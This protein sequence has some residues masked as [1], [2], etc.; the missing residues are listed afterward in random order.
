MI[1]IIIVLCLIPLL[2]SITVAGKSGTVKSGSGINVDISIPADNHPFLL[3]EVTEIVGL[4]E[5]NARLKPD[6]LSPA[7]ENSILKQLVIKLVPLAEYIPPDE[8][9]TQL[10]RKP[11]APLKS[12][13]PAVKIDHGKIVY[14]RIDQF[15]LETRK[16][17]KNE[18]SNI[19]AK[20][21]PVKGI[22]IDLRSCYG[23]DFENMIEA[24]RLLF[25][26]AGKIIRSTTAGNV[27]PLRLPVITLISGKTYGAAEVFAAV[28][29]SSPNSSTVGAATAGEPFKME[30]FSLS[31]GGRLSIPE[32]PVSI[33]E[34]PHFPV[35]PVVAAAPFPI[36]DFK[37]LES[38]ATS[39]QCI[40]VASD[41]LVSIN[42]LKQTS[43]KAQ[44]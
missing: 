7:I 31:N 12:A 8:V 42:T 9:K 32:I 40:C 15:S 1:K 39:D 29:A 5:K 4:L 30:Y 41:L 25:P 13:Y 16:L 6:K 2:T 21:S 3:P 43:V 24:C 19:Y 20:K 38:N 14:L 36:V 27:A 10:P 34:C 33:N 18:I 17:M 44:K 26:D 35:T 28:T 22:I 37:Q 23:F 11:I